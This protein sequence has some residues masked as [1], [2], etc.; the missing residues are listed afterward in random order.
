MPV[1]ILLPRTLTIPLSP[2]CAMDMQLVEAGSFM[3]G[4]PK[5]GYNSEKPV[6]QVQVRDFYLGKYQVTQAVWAAIMGGNPS[7]FKGEQRPVEKVSWDIAKV[8]IEK[9]NRHKE[10]QQY[11]QQLGYQ[12]VFRLPS[13]AEW[14][15][16]ARGGR[17]SQG[18]TYAGS[19]QLKQVGWFREN[20]ENGTSEVG[21]LL[22]NEL[23]LYDMSGNVWEW[24]EDD[25]HGTYDGAP[26]DGT[27]WVDTPRGARRVVRGGSFFLYAVHCR[28]ANRDGLTPDYRGGNRGFRL[29]LSL[30]SV[31]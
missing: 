16:A 23:G 26:T 24:C 1:E 25:W 19:D 13:E 15:Y 12:G 8:F 14:E 18:Y 9:L 6:H 17:Y 5:S 2:T 27:A 3:M 20:S 4:D 28:P 21:I 29:A 31:G 10:I 7:G 11:F 22:A 30:Q